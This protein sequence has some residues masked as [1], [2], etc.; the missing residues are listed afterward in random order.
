MHETYG[1]DVLGS[2]NSIS[3]M[4]DYQ[5]SA[6]HLASAAHSW[7]GNENSPNDSSAVAFSKTEIPDD[8]ENSDRYCRQIIRQQPQ[9]HSDHQGQ[10]IL[11]LDAKPEE[12]LDTDTITVTIPPNNELRASPPQIPYTIGK[13]I[14][15]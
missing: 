2:P 13:K 4:P 8:G 5:E 1:E 11:T 3:S 10:F 14:F 12:A 9:I 6:V 15:L 7:K